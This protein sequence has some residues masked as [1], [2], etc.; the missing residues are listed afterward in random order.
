MTQGLPGKLKVLSMICYT[1]RKTNKPPT[2]KK[3]AQKDKHRIKHTLPREHFL[4]LTEEPVKTLWRMLLEA[5]R[6]SLRDSLP[7]W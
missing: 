2:T 6:S 1:K 5:V 7:K 4:W 3:H